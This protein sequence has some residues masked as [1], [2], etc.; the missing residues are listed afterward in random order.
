MSTGE[1]PELG[2]IRPPV[3]LIAGPTASGKSDLAVR[4]ALSRRERGLASVVINADSAQVYRDLAVLSARPSEDEMQG[5]P[6]R[7]F[8]TWDGA[9]SCSAADWAAAAREEI[10]AAH[11]E[12]ALPILVGGTGMYHRTLIEGIAPVPRIDPEVREAVRALPVAEAYAALQ[13]EDPQRAAQLHANDSLRIARALEVVRSTG[14]PLAFWQQVST[15]GIQN[16]VALHPII[17]LPHLGT[18]RERAER[19]FVQMMETGAVQEVSAL[20]ARGLSPDLPVMRAIGVREIAGWLAGVWGRE[21]AIAR[22]QT[23]TWQYVR[24]QYTWF[25]R[26]PPA[27]WPRIADESY[28]SDSA[29][30]TLFSRLLLT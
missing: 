24:R 15:A 12:G 8:G 20:V 4:L 5:V 16:T 10:D 26:Q 1:P 23:A 17:L 30:E 6:H 18:I 29:I 2:G 3:A 28:L 7:L 21:E 11:A 13:S 14:Q 27:D 22:G 25:R 9:T 19:R